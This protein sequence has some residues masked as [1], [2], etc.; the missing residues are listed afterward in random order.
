MTLCERRQIS[1]QQA[2]ASGVSDGGSRCGGWHEARPSGQVSRQRPAFS[3]KRH[4]SAS[5]SS[6]IEQI[7]SMSRARG[8]VVLFLVWILALERGLQLMRLLFRQLYCETS[9]NL[10]GAADFP[11]P[12]H[13]GALGH[14]P[15][16]HN[17]AASTIIGHFDFALTGPQIINPHVAAAARRRA[18]PNHRFRGTNPSPRIFFF[19]DPTCARAISRASTFRRNIALSRVTSGWDQSFGGRTRLI[20]RACR[21]QG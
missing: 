19:T 20:I 5:A 8:G 7:C 21:R 13:P 14:R 10:R 16:S 11:I 12:H 1:E 4:L 17:E 15:H 2:P 6:T 18:C 3:S 9:G